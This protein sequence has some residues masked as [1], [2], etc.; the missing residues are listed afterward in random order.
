ME[1][2]YYDIVAKLLRKGAVIKIAYLFDDVMMILCCLS[3][4]PTSS[5]SLLLLLFRSIFL[6][7]VFVC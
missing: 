5:S 3:S 2:F 1:V 6:L 4:M 7:S